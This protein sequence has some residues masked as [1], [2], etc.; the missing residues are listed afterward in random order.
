[1]ELAIDKRV[2][3]FVGNNG[4]GKTNLLDAIYYLSFCKSYFNSID[5]QNVKFGNPF[6]VIQGSYL[7]QDQKVELYCGLKKGQKKQFKKNKKEYTRLADHIGLFPAVMISPYDSDLISEGS[8]I[9]RK[10]ID[11]IISQFDRSYLNGLISYNKL[12]SQRN[13]LLKKASSTGN[14]QQD[15][16]DVLDDQMVDYGQKIHTKRAKFLSSFIPVFQEYFEKISEGKEKVQIR[17][18]S[19]L[20]EGDYKEKLK[21]SL[22]KDS[23]LQYT[24]VGV[25]KDDLLFKIGDNPIKKFG[26]Q[27]QQKS[28]LISLKLAQY[29]YIKKEKEMNPI[30]LL[31]D[32]FDKLDEHRVRELIDTVSSSDFG[33][34]FITD[35]TIERIRLIFNDLKIDFQT[36]EIN[37]G[38]LQKT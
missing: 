11:S 37:N 22:Q 30:L 15:V 28:F 23:I 5:S 9:R 7:H 2:N 36:F 27:G 13:S 32:V 20:T 1:L 33:Q 25:H 21:L 8:E 3:C 14:F 18:K 10:L 17:Y 24:T 38:Q 12:L 19:H 31:D 26:S 29:K 4:A 16:L 6:F 35:T 34:V